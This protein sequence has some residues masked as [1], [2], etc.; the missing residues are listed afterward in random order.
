M[1]LGDPKFAAIARASV[2]GIVRDKNIVNDVLQANDEASFSVV[3]DL[4]NRRQVREFVVVADHQF[5]LELQLAEDPVNAV[6]SAPG[7]SVVSRGTW[8]RKKIGKTK[9]K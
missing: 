1:R 6:G 8:K 4:Q 2:R 9:V 7:E 3:A 5:I